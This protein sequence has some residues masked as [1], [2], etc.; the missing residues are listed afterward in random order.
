M[1]AAGNAA[2]SPRSEQFLA[3]SG[4]SRYQPVERIMK[5]ARALQIHEGTP[6]VLRTRIDRQVNS[7]IWLIAES[8]EP[9][10]PPAAHLKLSEEYLWTTTTT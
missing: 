2:H 1:A 4:Y 10:R 6:Q 5:D 8:A 7:R 9:Q 3:G